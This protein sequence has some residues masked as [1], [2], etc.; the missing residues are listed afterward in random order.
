MHRSR[1]T[2]VDLRD[3][4]SVGTVIPRPGAPRP[5]ALVTS[6]NDQSVFNLTSEEPGEI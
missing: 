2:P 3:L 6:L 4:K 5:G 1:H